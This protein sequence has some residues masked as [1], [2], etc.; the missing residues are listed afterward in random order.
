MDALDS[1][2]FCHNIIQL[3]Q[4]L[5]LDAQMHDCHAV[6]FHFHV[7]LGNGKFHFRQCR[8]NIRHQTGSIVADDFDGY[9]E[10]TACLFFPG[11]ID[12]SVL[13]G[14]IDGIGTVCPMH[15]H[16]AASGNKPYDIITRHR[17]A[18]LGQVH[19]Q[20]FFPFHQHSAVGTGLHAP[21]FQ[22]FQSFGCL[23]GRRFLG[24]QLPF[25]KF[26]QFQY[27]ALHCHTAKSHGS[28]HIFGVHIVERPG[29]L[30]KPV[31]GNQ[32]LP[33]IPQPVRFLDKGF[34]TSGNI[35]AA[36]FLLEPAPDFR[37]GVRRSYHIDPV[38]AGFPGFG[39]NN[40][41]N[42]A[43]LQLRIQRHDFVI[44]LGSHAA[45]SHFRMDTIG[46]IDRNRPFR[47]VNDIPFRREHE[48]F[49]GE[50]IQ[51]QGIHEFLGIA[52]ILPL[53]NAAEPAD[54]SVKVFGTGL[55]S[56]LV[57]PVGSHAIF[58]N[59]VH[60]PG[61]DLYFHR[62]SPGA[63]NRGMKGLVHVGLRHRN[64]ILESV[65]QRFP[66][67]MG[68]TQHRI[69]LG[70]GIHNDSH[71]IEVVNLGQ[72]LIIPFH[73]LINAVE[74]LGSAGN[75]SLNAGF[76]D[77]VMEHPHGII[78]DFFTG[79]PL[80]FHLPHQIVVFF[81]MQ[82]METEIFQF[83]LNVVDTEA[84]SQGRIDFNSFLGNAL[85][86]LPAEYSKGSHIVQ[87]VC[88]L[89]DHHSNILGHG[90]EHFTEIFQLLVFLIFIVELGKL[91]HPVYQKGYFLAKHH[92]DIFQRIFRILHYIVKKSRHNALG[93]HFQLRQ[94][95]GYSQR[96]DDIRLSGGPDLGCMG[97]AGQLI[98]LLYGL[99]ALWILDIGFHLIHE[100]LI[101]F[102]FFAA[103][104]FFLFL[105]FH[106]LFLVNQKFSQR[107]SRGI[108]MNGFFIQIL[109]KNTGQIGGFW[110]SRHFFFLYI[111][112]F[113]H[114]F[115]HHAHPPGFYAFY[116]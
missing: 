77:M 41:N 63:D 104:V 21:H 58:R 22:I 23:L 71:C 16:A 93:I 45:V 42:I 95:V 15:R 25:V 7:G 108:G 91:C 62:L 67:G 72:I 75:G 86:F 5:D 43:V 113:I 32:L 11:H 1:S 60:F 74:M 18:A 40:G 28:Q 35:F 31:P 36:V 98:G 66:Q 69:A 76:L 29:H 110:K 33:F 10:H 73:F 114:I 39:R 92:L 2:D 100:A 65:G 94:N 112:F 55:F 115:I 103:P 59:M 82:V 48:N 37:L 49:I 64:V 90:Q 6:V 85:L 96:V 38:V 79:F 8:Q 80:L 116:K 46:K 83:P 14:E 84:M 81:R 101:F 17:V 34:L 50:Y 109:V 78:D 89:D 47:K 52:G 12:H 61:T 105:P 107:G 27:D 53:K 51:L 97:L 44:D 87:T 24:I 3:L 102:F 56:F 26:R 20:S 70:D 99:Q 111:F 13:I 19:H 106:I 9:Q 54:F 4:V 30:G 57:P 68:N 88:Q